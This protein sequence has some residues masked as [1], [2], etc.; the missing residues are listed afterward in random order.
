MIRILTG[1]NLKCDDIV[2]TLKAF[3]EF[4]VYGNVIDTI[5]YEYYRCLVKK[6][7]PEILDKIFSYCEKNKFITEISPDHYQS[8]L[9]IEERSFKKICKIIIRDRANI[10]NDRIKSGKIKN[11]DDFVRFVMDFLEMMAQ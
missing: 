6:F 7:S 8:F 11:D 9:D 4:A 10:I 2:N 5:R 1:Q 3:R